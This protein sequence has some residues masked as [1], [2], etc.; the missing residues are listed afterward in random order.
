MRTQNGEDRYIPDI[1]LADETVVSYW[2]ER[3]RETTNPIMCARYADLV[4]EFG[5]LVTQKKREVKFAR[6]AAEAY[7]RA[8]ETKYY[9][10]H[11]HAS[12]FFTRA[13]SLSISIN[14]QALISRSKDAAFELNRLIG[15]FGKG[16]MWWFLFDTLYDEN[17]VSL[18]DAERASII[19]GLEHVLKIASDRAQQEL[20]D[21]WTAQG[22]AERLERHYRKIQ[23]LDEVRR[24]AEIAGLSFEQAAND[25]EPLLA[26]AWL[27]TVYEKYRDLGMQV[28]ASRAHRA[29]EEKSKAAPA[30]MKRVEVPIDIDPD[31]LKQYI[32]TLTD[33]GVTKALLKVAARFIPKANDVRDFNERMKDVAPLSSRISIRIFEGEF[34]SAVVG[35]QEDDPD[36][37]LIHQIG[38][39]ISF[40]APFLAMALNR[41]V[42]RYQ[43]TSEQVMELLT[44]SP[45]V[46]DD[47]K[48]LLAEGVAAALSN[49]H[50][51]AIHVLVPQ[52]EHMLRSLAGQIGTPK[53]TAGSKKGTMQARALGDI[54]SDPVLKDTL[55]EDI[56]LYLVALLVDQRGLNLRNRVAHGLMELHQ[57]DRRLSDRLLHVLLT[58][59]L[60]S[61]EIRETIQRFFPVVRHSYNDDG[62]LAERAVI[63]GQ[64]RTKDEALEA[65]KSEAAKN[66]P[67]EFDQ[68][69]NQWRIT[70]KHGKTHFLLVEEF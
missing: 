10:D 3:S 37:R 22:A 41:I 44:S 61:V 2:G 7:L 19:N 64:H 39:Q 49:D 58:L 28:A 50:V 67:W 70:D 35:S 31:E 4:W 66:S 34:A 38:R 42:D 53:T 63:S 16:R 17:A 52:I 13:L 51:K 45:L 55:D 40:N 59:R 8:V 56:R 21:P 24:V 12:N 27:Q 54:L 60:I 30:G 65:A 62:L 25:A 46:D 11:F 48:S 5:P 26:V 9:L 57:L 33:G 47:R 15:P 69:N 36:G 18:T 68:A 32:E 1:K 29:L 6:R 14:D 20:F 23:K 43:T